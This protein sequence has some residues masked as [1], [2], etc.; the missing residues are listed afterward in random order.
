MQYR[1]S[2]GRATSRRPDRGLP[3][4]AT[5]KVTAFAY[6]KGCV[7]VGGAKPHP[8]G[9]AALN[10]RPP[11]PRQTRGLCIKNTAALKSDVA[12]FLLAVGNGCDEQPR[13][14]APAALKGCG[15]GARWGA[16]AQFLPKARLGSHVVDPGRR[17]ALFS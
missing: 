15:R 11:S 16:T 10:H 17:V 13:R 5:G 12:A 3:K 14:A 7:S 2:T 4:T 8:V 9:V 1:T 6:V